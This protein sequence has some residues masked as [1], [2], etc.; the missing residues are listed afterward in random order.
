M[1]IRFGVEGLGPDI[2]FGLETPEREVSNQAFW[3]ATG[4]LAE[5]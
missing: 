5:S 2:V 4:L 3:G 1:N